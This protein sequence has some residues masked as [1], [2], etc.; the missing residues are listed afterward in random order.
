MR[1][2]NEANL[3]ICLV[4]L[5]NNPDHQEVIYSL[6]HELRMRGYDAHTVGITKPKTSHAEF[7]QWNHFVDAP[8][9]P[10]ITKGT[11]D[12]GRLRHAIRVIREIMPTHAYFETVHIWD[13]PILRALRKTCTTYQVVHD[14]NPHDGSKAVLMANRTCARSADYA[15]IRNKKDGDLCSEKYAIPRE[16]VLSLDSWR[17]FFPFDPPTYSENVL[18]FGRLRKYKGLDNLLEIA[19]AAPDISFKVMGR[20]DE[21]STRV[22]RALEQLP[23]VTVREGFAESEDMDR[24][25]HETDCVIVPYESASQSGIIMDAYRYSRPV[26]AYDVGAIS[27]QV[28]DGETGYLIEA[29][30]VSGFILAIRK[31]LTGAE[32][33]LSTMAQAAYDFGIEKYSAQSAVPGFLAMLNGGDR[34]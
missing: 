20:S 26:V 25:F 24:A 33:P 29:G 30:D 8:L 28:L 27:E 9:R 21:E 6:C 17:A 32:I 1:V 22:V 4:C 31:V 16:R 15:V 11:F 12:I 5:S 23:N 18:F 14:V 3:R 2:H 13:V 10:G 19:K 34:G 7:E